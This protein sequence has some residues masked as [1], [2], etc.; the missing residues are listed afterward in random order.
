MDRLH[1]QGQNLF[2]GSFLLPAAVLLE[3]ALTHNINLMANYC[4]EYGMLL[5]PHGKTT[6]SPEIIGRQI[7]AGAWAIT[8]A[9]AG[10][11]SA[12]ID[13]GARRILLAN[14]VVDAGSLRQIDRLLQAHPDLELFCYVDSIAG[15]SILQEQLPATS[16][17]RLRVLVELGFAGGRSGVRSVD[18]ALDLAR[19]IH[20]GSLN[21][22]GIAAFEGILDAGDLDA[23]L[24]LVDHLLARMAQLATA[25]HSEGL[26]SEPQ[27]IVT[28]GGS[29]YFDRVVRYLPAA[30]AGTEFQ[31]VLRSGCYVTHD[32]G[33]YEQLSP[34]GHRATSNSRLR[35]ALEVWA[36]VLSRPEP[37][38]AIIGLG[39]RDASADAGLPVP[40]RVR[41]AT[42][43][44]TAPGHDWRAVAIND[45]H[46]HLELPPDA[47]LDVGQLMAFGISHPCTTFDKWRAIPIVDPQY[48]VLDVAHPQF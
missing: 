38:K 18:D 31:T 47:R 32:S 8:V 2:D 12:V 10:Q 36:P 24:A 46:I 9:T 25:V 30:L 23:T 13:M 45:Q 6:M 43:E 1:N 41:N 7:K 11:A 39:R 22:A 44:M 5:A 3:E 15:L 16:R 20:G 21:L 40:L 42:G 17:D 27:P 29:A 37:R 48:N 34:L 26:L 35:P 19:R 4:V 33:T 28:M 14:Q